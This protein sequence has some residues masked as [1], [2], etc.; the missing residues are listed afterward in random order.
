MIIYYDRTCDEIRGE[1]LYRKTYKFKKKWFRKGKLEP[2][3]SLYLITKR[4]GNIEC[5]VTELCSD[6][7]FD[8][9][10]LVYRAYIEGVY[11]AYVEGLSY[12]TRFMC[13]SEDYTYREEYE[14]EF[15][16]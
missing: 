3:Y 11:R 14:A 7:D 10:M 1:L 13:G 15:G 12:S 5:E 16:Y 6:A 4:N 2:Q 9:Y 8:T